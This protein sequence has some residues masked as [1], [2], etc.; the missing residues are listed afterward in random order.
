MMARK[1]KRVPNKFER[2]PRPYAEHVPW[3]SVV[4]GSLLAIFPLVATHGWWPDLG[5]MMLIAWRMQRSDPFPNWY[6][7][8]LGLLNDLLLLHPLGLS[9]V[10]FTFALL[11]VDIIDARKLRGFYAT[12]W[13]VAA[14]L[15]AL[16]KLLQLWVA[17][18]MDAPMPL[19]S[20]LPPIV[21]S[22][23]LFPIMAF[24]VTLLDRYRLRK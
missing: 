18:I 22:V 10:T 11:V 16:A 21:I 8:P 20:I 24:I 12:E 6:A 19:L 13:L 17:A 7:I 2:G 23:L 1:R 14:V 5:L 9:V 3:T 4:A 15:I